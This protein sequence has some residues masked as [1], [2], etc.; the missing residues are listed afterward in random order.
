MTKKKIRVAFYFADESIFDL[1]KKWRTRERLVKWA[2]EFFGQNRYGFV[3]DEFP[4]AN[5]KKYRQDF[6]LKASNGPKATMTVDRIME[7][8]KENADD[9]SKSLRADHE[10]YKSNPPQDLQERVNKLNDLIE[11]SKISIDMFKIVSDY[12]RAIR[13]DVL[14]FRQLIHAKMSKSKRL[15]NRVVVV[16]CKFEDPLQ[17]IATDVTVGETFKKEEQEVSLFLWNLIP[18][19]VGYYTKPLI[20]IDVLAMTKSKECTLA[21]EIVHA[22]GPTTED[23]KGDPGNIMVYDACLKLPPASILL[24]DEDKKILEAA[25]FVR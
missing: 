12:F 22:A 9:Y 14:E 4:S 2:N 17:K 23:N 5:E 11:R 10:S 20:L 16:F 25:Y 15:D 3:I 7:K 19:S 6:S 24:L 21:H 8:F 13:A 18:W 1:A